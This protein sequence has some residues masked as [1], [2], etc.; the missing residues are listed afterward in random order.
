MENGMQ[1]DK[2]YWKYWGKTPRSAETGEAFCH[3]LA[4]HC[5]D[6][7]AVGTIYLRRHP[8]LLAD[9]A[10]RLRLPE[11][12]LSDWLA[13]FLALHDLGKFSHGFQSLRWKD[14]CLPLGNR[15]PYRNYVVR[16]DTLGQALYEGIINPLAV[17]NWFGIWADAD[18]KDYWTDNF[19]A[20][21]RAAT[22]HHGQPPKLADCRDLP[23]HFSP[24]DQTAALEFA[25][26]CSRLL[27]PAT[28]DR[29][30][31]GER[32]SEAL[33]PLTWWLAGFA[34]LSDWLGSN[35]AFFPYRSQPMPLAEYWQK[36]ALPQAERA[37]ADANLLPRA[38]RGQTLQELFAYLRQPTPLQRQ[39]AE[40]S[41]DGDPQLFILEDVTGAGKTEAAL[42]LTHR[43]LAMGQADSFY[44][45]LPTM[46][47]SNAMFRRIRDNDLPDKFFEGQV[48]LVL[49]HSA[50]RLAPVF[51]GLSKRI[52]TGDADYQQGEAS[53]SHERGA[54]FADSRKKA[55]LAD[56]GVGTLD[57]ALLAVLYCRHQSLRLLGLARKV[58]VVDEVHACDAY[59]LKLLE[60]LL[61]FH[62][63]AGGS[64]ILLSA[65]LPQQTRQAL[66]NAYCKGFGRKAA[67][68][69]Q[70]TAYPL[71]TRI[72]QRR[73]DEIPLDTR[74]EVAR[75]VAV[76]M[77]H[78]QDDA[79]ALL[80]T[81]QAEGRCA[82]WIRNTVDDAIAAC[83]ALRQ[84]GVNPDDLMLFHARYALADR[85]AIENQVLDLF[86][87]GSGA[88]KRRGKVLVATQVVEQSLD[89]DFDFLLS[90]LAPVDLL[91]QRAGRLCRH[92]RDASGNRASSEGRGTPK[93][94]I[95]SPE[96]SEEPA[97][98]WLD[99]VLPGAA[100]VYPDVGRLW[101]TARLL[102][103]AQALIMPGE[104][105]QPGGARSLVEGVYGTK[106]EA[107]IPAAF[108]AKTNKAEAEKSAKRSMGTANTIKFGLPYEHSGLDP[109]DDTCI[110][111]RLEDQ[112]SVI[113][114]LARLENGALRPW[115]D[116]ANP[117]AW[118]L[119][120]LSVRCSLF[121]KEAH[122]PALAEA[123]ESC[124]AAMP[125]RGKWSKVLVLVQEGSVWVG[126]A[127]N[128]K[129]E[130][131]RLCYDPD[132][133]LRKM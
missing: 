103:E 37:L 96:F 110:P 97:A 132:T 112:P 76:G 95:F 117:H 119:S 126:Q 39:A 65:T 29:L 85:L 106:A 15:Q 5:L 92:V 18:D 43:L 111:T 6:V 82:C 83:E 19:K 36:R 42:L 67:S 125:D 45:G 52:G 81:A 118:E 49:A 35:E 121:A 116:P 123:V 11:A 17:E 25:T 113:V 109:W 48:N 100:A 107:A 133:G 124:R 31:D 108:Q 23:A 101:L 24:I 69:L 54:W 46:A 50:S 105:G 94:W 26:D 27:L 89:L 91:I 62:A 74:P 3:L 63:A 87:P 20:L 56:I 88:A 44:F 115:H 61:T 41:L 120:Q 68:T 90:D 34:V 55:L 128:G 93:L 72:A 114:R 129:G 84:A 8:A 64:A 75:T 131:V 78:S 77:V 1:S 40:L 80:R 9:W 10:S 70:S 14:I 38:V 71:L 53:A 58:L 102:R 2:G 60:V 32:F 51:E 130:N 122:D 7:A 79:F 33:N 66:A 104:D 73:Q 21:A 127:E 99:K 4:Y 86:G 30:P 57:Q 22:G 28:K 13:F 59:M 16:H 98:D 12:N 47:T